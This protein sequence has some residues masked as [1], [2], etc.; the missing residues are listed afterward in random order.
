MPSK[1]RDPFSGSALVA[2]ATGAA[3]VWVA[4]RRSCSFNG[5]TVV[6][7]GGSRGLGLVLA[8]EFARE[9]ARL[10]LLARDEAELERAKADLKARGAG[11]VRVVPCDVRA[12][13]EVSVAIQCVVDEFRRIDVLVNNAG[14]MQVGPLEHMTIADFEEAMAVHFYGPLFASLAVI[15]HMRRWGGGR[16]V[17]I[18]S[19]G[20]KI[21][22]PHLVPYSASKFALVGLS[23][24][25]RSELRRHNIHVT[26][27]CPGLMRTGSAPNASFKGR[28]RDEWFSIADS[29]P[30]ASLNARRTRHGLVGRANRRCRGRFS[31]T[32][33]VRLPSGTTRFQ[34]SS[35]PRRDLCSGLPDKAEAES[36][37]VRRQ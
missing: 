16:I 23:E 35:N 36:G 1:H 21:A 9:G 8:R 2:L 10:V 11:A 28:H 15:P 33:R 30:V 7:T 6:I 26:T 12:R 14:V 18:A 32:G 22:M 13:E 29:L 20:G 34:V 27:V 19:I 4:N 17:N 37:E 31:P 25:L 3:A 5:R 24:G